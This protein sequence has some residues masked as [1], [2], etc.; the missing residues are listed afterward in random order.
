MDLAVVIVSYNTRELI[1]N[2]LASI[3]QELEAFS[4]E[5]EV[6]VIDN[7]SQDGS[8]Q[9]I[10]AQFPQV[11]LII[12]NENLGF[13]RGINDVMERIEQGNVIPDFCLLLNPDTL[14]QP[15]AVASL[16]AFMRSCPSAAAAGAQLLYP[17]GSFQQGAF[18]FPTLPM[19]FLIFGRSTTA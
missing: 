19:I 10:A 13:A 3:F 2:C 16:L 8:A 12:S 14:I 1:L 17:D 11:K 15:G 9:A 6:W 5:S 18:H 4:L 7:A